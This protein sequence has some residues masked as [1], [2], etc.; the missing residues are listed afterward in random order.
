MDK[1]IHDQG[2]RVTISNDGATIVKLL[3]V[4]HPAAKALVDVSLSQDAE[5]GDGT[6][7][8]VLLAAELLREAKPFVEDGVHPRAIIRAYRAAAETAVARVK[9]LSVSLEGRPES[10]LRELLV[11][12]AETSLNSKLVSGEKHFFAEMVV[13]AV[14]RLDPATG[15]DLRMIGIK[16]A[17][18][19][20]LRDSFLVDGVAFRKTFSYAGFEQQ[21]KLFADGPKIL[22]LNIELELKS[23]RENAEVRRVEGVGC[24]CCDALTRVCTHALSLSPRLF[25]A[26]LPNTQTNEK[27]NPN[28]QPPPQTTPETP[29]QQVRLDD[30]S[31]YQ[32]LVDAEWNIIYDKLAKCVAS[33]ASVVLSRLAIGDL[34]TQYFADRGVFCAGR[35][36]TED[37]ERVAKA[38]GARVQTTVNNLDA[39]QALG[40]CERFEERQ[41][42]GDRYNLFTG[43]PAAKTATLV[44]R[45]GSEQFIDEAE[46]SLH[47]A[48]CIVRR[49]LKHAQVVP[50]GG[51]VDM[52]ASAALR[53]LSLEIAGK[54]QLFTAAFA[55]ALEVIPRQLCDNSGFDATDVLNK[56]RQKHAAAAAAARQAEAQGASEAEVAAAA[57]AAGARFGVDVNTG[58]VVDTFGAFVWEPALVKVN[59]LQSAT[60]AACLVLSV[61]ETVRNPKSESAEAMGGAM[62]GPGRGGGRGGGMGGRGMRR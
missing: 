37:M 19:G 31:Q 58:G 12:C 60:E 29:K 5:V 36:P 47:D 33:G 48:I 39:D 21:P 11:R 42:G 30:P 1:L 17:P 15:H 4:V 14:S 34:A 51:A 20:G 46:R 26:L 53:G 28:Q 52:A 35:V 2:G 6:T 44:L 9:A 13:D 57:V 24:V 50:G 27:T 59:A 61:D 22:L 8:V 55:R 62:R 38:T 54:A 40:R 10:E 56:L 41:V 25:S 45:G 3:D 32:A 16:K 43:C 18:G 23:E 7:T 49:A